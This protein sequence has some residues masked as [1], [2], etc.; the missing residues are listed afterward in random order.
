MT[1]FWLG[2]TFWKAIPQS[3]HEFGESWVCAGEQIIFL[4]VEGRF[5]Q[6][7]ELRFNYICSVIFSLSC[8]FFQTF[9]H[10][11]PPQ[12]L[13]STFLP[14]V[15][16]HCH[17]SVP[18]DSAQNHRCGGELEG[19]GFCSLWPCHLDLLPET[20]SPLGS[21][22]FCKERICKKNI[23][24]EILLMTTQEQ[25]SGVASRRFLHLL[26]Q[27]SW[28]PLKQQGPGL[29]HERRLNGKQE[30]RRHRMCNGSSNSL[31]DGVVYWP[32][33]HSREHC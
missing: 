8:F 3:Q 5:S 31:H 21:N 6:H 16:K 28:S 27:L 11:L 10:T 23:H 26:Q 13:I 20:H 30:P 33:R 1:F 24:K 15:P 12:F 32:L 22:S 29:A 4:C 14:S 17:C 2:R 25:V 18:A 19:T 7:D 9:I